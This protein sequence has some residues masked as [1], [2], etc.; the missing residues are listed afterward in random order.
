MKKNIDKPLDQLAK[1]TGILPFI[2]KGLPVSILFPAIIAPAGFIFLVPYLNLAGAIFLVPLVI[3]LFYRGFSNKLYV[4][5]IFTRALTGLLSLISAWFFACVLAG[6]LSGVYGWEPMIMEELREFEPVEILENWA[7]IYKNSFIY[8][9]SPVR[10]FE[11][12]AAWNEN[13]WLTLALAGVFAQI[14]LPQF[15][16]KKRR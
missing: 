11:D 8:L 6:T 15:L 3:A 16:V 4:D 5:E 14:G 13:G 7:A 10:L 2:L 12:L 9:Y 1:K